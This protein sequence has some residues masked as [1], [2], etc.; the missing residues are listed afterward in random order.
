MD[1]GK[2]SKVQMYLTYSREFGTITI[3]MYISW[4]SPFLA[5]LSRQKL[6]FSWLHVPLAG[7]GSPDGMEER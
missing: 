6:P 3:P 7:L 5:A 4:V 1:I 2:A